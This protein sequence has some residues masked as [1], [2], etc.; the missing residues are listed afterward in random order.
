M[1][2][3]GG[4]GAAGATVV[5][6]GFWRGQGAE[7]SGFQERHGMK[8]INVRF[9]LGLVLVALL[10]VVGIVLTNRYQIARNA[11]S[12]VTMARQKVEE[13]KLFDALGLYGRYLGLRPNDPEVLVEYAELVLERALQPDAVQA[14][15]SR[16]YNTLEEALRK[17]PENIDLRR[18]L[19]EFQM[20]IGRFVDA[21]EHLEALRLR[22]STNAAPGPDK[23][24]PGGAPDADG[25]GR[26]ETKDAEPVAIDL[27]LARSYYG[28]GDVERAVSIASRLVGYDVGERRFDP[29][30]RTT[31]STEA[32]ILMAQIL[33]ERFQDGTAAND[34]LQSLV[35]RHGDD[36]NAWLALSR[37]H[38]QA[39]DFDA[40][41]AAVAKA[42]ALAPD[43]VNVVFTAFEI[44][45]A[46]QDFA[47]AQRIAERA[48][49]LFPGD[50]RV[51]RGLASLA[52]QRGDLADA[53]RVL[54]E[55]VGRLPSK[56]SLLLMLA[57]TLLQ[58]RKIDETDN[59]L[60]RIR[61]LYGTTSPA[62]GLLEARLLMERQRWPQARQKLQQI[63]PIAVGLS[64]LIRQIDLCLSQCHERL[65]E[66]DEQLEINRRLL[67]DD[68]TSLAA[69]VGTAAALA[70]AGRSNDA[71]KEYEAVA[72]ALP[73]ERLTASPQLWYP[74]LQLRLREQIEKPATDRD[75]TRVDDILAAL[76]ASATMSEEQL[77]LLRADVLAR[78]GEEAV[79]INLLRGLASRPEAGPQ[80]W[81]ALVSMVFRAEGE[82]AA[83]TVLSSVPRGMA[84]TPSLLLLEAQLA[85][86]Q[87]PDT[88]AATLA[89][90]EKRANALPTV[91]ATQML[92]A[93][94]GVWLGRGDRAEG[95][96]LLREA[97][98]RQP[99]DLRSRSA[100]LEIAMNAGDL[101]SA[102]AAA[103]ELASVAG[104]DTARANV[105]RASVK[106]LEVRQAQAAKESAAGR[107]ELSASDKR[108]LD[109]A[110]SLLIQAENDR[111]GWNV[112]QRY[113][114]EIDG[115]RGDIPA[116]ID[117]LQRAVRMGPASP[118]LVRQLVALLYATNRLDEARLALDSLSA[119]DLTGL[120]R[121]S[122][123]MELRS[124]KL[125]EAVALAE[126][127]VSRDSRSAADL[128]WLGQLLERSGKTDR[129][130]EVFAQAVTVD[131]LRADAWLSLFAQQLSSGRRRAAE[132][133][134]DRAASHLSD[135]QRQLVLA[136][137]SEMLGRIDDAARHL[138]AAER[139]APADMNVGRITAEFMIRNGRL[140][141]AR[142]TLRRL[143]ATADDDPGG[144]AE[145]IAATRTWAR[146]RLAGLI[147]ERGTYRDLEEGLE[148]LRQNAGPDGSLDPEDLKLEIAM[149]VSRPEP[150]SW[151]QAVA[152]LDTLRKKQPLTT[153][154]RLTR[155]GL[156]EKLGR[157]DECRNELMSIVSAPKTPPSFVG[158]LVEKMIDHGEQ[159]NARS[160]L[161]RLEERAPTA[162]M[163]LA[164]Q[165]RLA[166]AM[167][168]RAA[169]VAA[170]RK[171]MPAGD[172]PADQARQQ[173]AIAKLFEDLRFT[174][175]ADQLHEKLAPLSTE[176]TLAR[177]EFLG[178]QQRTEEAFALLDT[179]WESISLD[180]LLTSAMGVARMA[181]DVD[182]AAARLDAWLGKAT[183]IDPG[184]TTIP[185]IEAEVRN[186]QRRPAEAE[187]IY[188]RLLAR[189]DLSPM[190]R[191][192]VSNNLAFQLASPPTATE[193]KRLIDEAIATLGPHPD[194]LDTRALV[195]LALGNDADA[196]ADLRLAVLQPSDVKYLH[197]AYA[198]MRTGS[199]SAAREHLDA[200]RKK[201]LVAKRLSAADRLRL[202]ELENTLGIVPE[203]AEAARLPGPPAS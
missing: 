116:A 143:L 120:E 83:R 128:L 192:I 54:Q 165:A 137:G 56:A 181:D 131:P 145:S 86:R 92:T 142:T 53:E 162:P 84:D 202:T 76:E 70:A 107:I 6:C 98:A 172:V 185:L 36:P 134:L 161:K 101:A 37:W 198:E 11:G 169:A 81:A 93:L 195:L 96:R 118:E 103:E 21:R 180:R 203:Q 199:M 111:S 147:A 152:A 2:P 97:A 57:D 67:V 29:D 99:D 139:A 22:E 124:G 18:K 59:V 25:G 12:L 42:E 150:S 60:E 14:D 55:G 85:A 166:V 69:R 52:L 178:R 122:A 95:E 189:Q 184:S 7:T 17:S 45:L 100:L 44:A 121:L 164:L 20:R 126:S 35:K 200:G 108:L 173:G 91:E 127:A 38:R 115:L 157:W 88:A 26:G 105:A 114:A 64:E 186:L 33:L 148:L 176:A 5:D 31:G 171:L 109:E 87:P 63:R 24:A 61:E 141:P 48:H 71:L 8:R 170:S 72:A 16:A 197:L 160:W 155:A 75:W 15:I 123:E 153:A 177:G 102:A 28:S 9:L 156:L 125:E 10:G 136:Q 46:R 163:T 73:P 4:P 104:D 51:Y 117:R 68:P 23:P 159:A 194:L 193:A 140:E 179:L 39:G 201:G 196:V 27:L 50:E 110:R 34:V 168:D 154:D 1:G 58:Q 190:Q 149:L 77:A 62:V 135:P 41:V 138:E 89:D 82:D 158:M 90:I 80:V 43:N 146:R 175:A 49:E 65:D 40:A 188:R 112:I 3:R 79:A 129:A 133:T 132:N 13:G 130:G 144:T 74:L 151:Q 183:R 119:A 113:H 106:I 167:N 187:A 94:A 174:K 30:L 32:Y 66:F 19:A 78:K 191:A 47:G 182:A